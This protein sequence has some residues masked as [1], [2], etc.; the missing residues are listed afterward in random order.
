M[1]CTCICASTESAARRHK[2]SAKDAAQAA[3]ILSALVNLRVTPYAAAQEPV[4]ASR[5]EPADVEAGQRSVTSSDS[6]SDR[7]ASDQ[8]VAAAK[9][10]RLLN[11]PG[12][13][14]N[15]DAYGPALRELSNLFSTGA[16]AGNHEGLQCQCSCKLMHGRSLAAGAHS[17]LEFWN[18]DGHL[19]HA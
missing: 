8:Q 16:S 15:P 10:A 14:V 9:Q 1:T 7:T 18:N 6:S 19:G 4:Q 3:T 12:V 2:G 11:Y 13:T 5:P 17:L